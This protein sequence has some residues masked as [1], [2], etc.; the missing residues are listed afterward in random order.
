MPRVGR[1][2]HVGHSQESFHRNAGNFQTVK[3]LRFDFRDDLFD[4]LTSAVPV[5]GTESGRFNHTGDIEEVPTGFF[6]SLIHSGAV[7]VLDQ[8]PAM[9]IGFALQLQGVRQKGSFG[10]QDV[11]ISILFTIPPPCVCIVI[12]V[13]PPFSGVLRTDRHAPRVSTEHPEAEPDASEHQECD[14]QE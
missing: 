5:V 13:P 11:S 9:S 8:S 12:R 6:D 10:D 14:C 4:R 7:E 2:A 1:D 3:F